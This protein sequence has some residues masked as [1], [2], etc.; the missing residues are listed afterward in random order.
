MQPFKKTNTARP[1]RRS[2]KLI[3]AVL[4]ELLKVVLFLA[5]GAALGMVFYSGGENL[6]GW[7]FFGLLAC[8]LGVYVVSRIYR[9]TVLCPL[10]FGTILKTQGCRKHDKAHRIFFLT[11]KATILVDIL[12]GLKFT[13]IYCG[14]RF[15]LRK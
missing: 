5:C 15:R 14:T 1:F 8:F 7:L 3:M 13:C 12:T 6:Y 10:C 9:N 4:I 11:Y 2:E